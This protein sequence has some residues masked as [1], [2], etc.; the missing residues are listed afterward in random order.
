MLIECLVILALI[1]AVILMSWM[2]NKKDAAIEMVPLLFVPSM[3][4]VANY[5]CSPLSSIVKVDKLAVFTAMIVF[6]AVV[7]SL[8][9]G[10]FA[11]RFKT[12]KTKAMYCIM[13]ISF[14]VLIL[15][16]FVIDLWK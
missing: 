13:S 1:L 5:L 9:V 4:V 11:S 15:L 2:K 14:N 16:V 3:Y 10:F 7:S 6:S 12:K 8:F